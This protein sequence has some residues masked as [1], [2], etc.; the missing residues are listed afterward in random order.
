MLSRQGTHQEAQK[1]SRTYFPFKDSR[2]TGF[3]SLSFSVNAGAGIPLS[4]ALRERISSRAF[5]PSR[6]L[7]TRS[8]KLLKP[9]SY[10]SKGISRLNT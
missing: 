6:L 1:S 5:L 7:R 8:V 2:E 3:P 4:V 10:S 9:A